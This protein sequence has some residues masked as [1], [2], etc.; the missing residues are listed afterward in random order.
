MYIYLKY[1]FVVPLNLT[2]V[3]PPR[4]ATPTTS[5]QRG[6]AQLPAA[7]PRSSRPQLHRIGGRWRQ[8]V[9]LLHPLASAV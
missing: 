3:I 2:I 1:M 7:R 8:C 6:G 5:H 4:Q 9:R